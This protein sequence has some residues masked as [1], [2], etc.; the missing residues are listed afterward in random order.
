MVAH[1]DW[2]SN[3]GYHSFELSLPPLSYPTILL[4]QFSDIHTW[5]GFFSVI[6]CLWLDVGLS[7]RCPQVVWY[8]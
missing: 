1:L 3:S 4:T 6:V 7:P 5:F 8:H 2:D